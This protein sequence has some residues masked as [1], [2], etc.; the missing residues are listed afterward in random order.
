MF[1]ALGM[2]GHEPPSDFGQMLSFI[3]DFTPAHVVAAMRESVPLTDGTCHR[4]PTSRWRRYDR[5]RRFPRGLLVM[6][7]ADT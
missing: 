4:M 6:G 2:A 3:E 5:M 7:D 1:T